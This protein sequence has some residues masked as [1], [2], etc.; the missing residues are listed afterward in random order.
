VKI[1]LRGRFQA[2]VQRHV[3]VSGPAAH[4]CVQAGADAHE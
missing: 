1:N 4:E 2:A 3:G